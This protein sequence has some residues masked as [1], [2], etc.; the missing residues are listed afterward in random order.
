MGITFLILFVSFVSYANSLRGKFIWDDNIMVRDNESIRNWHSIPR[1]LTHDISFAERERVGYYRPLLILSYMWDYAIWKLNPFGF[2][3]TNIFLHFLTGVMAFWMLNLITGNRLLCLFTSLLFVSHPIQSE[4]VAYISG[5]SDILAAFFILLSFV[6]YIKYS[7]SPGVFFYVTL[8][9]VYACALFSKESSLILPALIAV[10]QWIFKKKL[11]LR[12]LMPLLQL[13]VFYCLFRS[14]V[15]A[16]HAP[17]VDTTVYERLPGFF[18]AL[19]N[20]LRLLFAPYGLHMEYG[21]K[22]FTFSTP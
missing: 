15:L 10:Y 4:A 2:H 1:A 3:L 8:L 17:L 22:L 13:S 21:K 5:R 16:V 9:L 12:L 6:V 20:Y 19:S 11:N 18:V 14:F 7:E